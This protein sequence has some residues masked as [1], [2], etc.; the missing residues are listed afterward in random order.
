MRG[1]FIMKKKRKLGWFMLVSVLFI[2]FVL[3]ILLY[4]NV[5]Q[6]NIGAGGDASGAVSS[7]DVSDET[8]RKVEEVQ[9]TVGKEHRD[10][11]ERIAEAHQFYNKTTGYGAIKSLDWEEQRDEAALLN[12]QLEKNLSQVKHDALQK[13]IQKLIGLTGDVAHEEEKETIIHI[14]RLVHDL[15]IALNDYSGYD[16]IWNVTETLKQPTNSTD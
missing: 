6:F 16:K 15:D 3:I 1:E 9:K 8:K 5:F 4:S 14:H 2:T 10:I 12:A 7:D 13:D 11:G